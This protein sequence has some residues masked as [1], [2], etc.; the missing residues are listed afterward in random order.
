MHT[1]SNDHITESSTLVQVE[2]S[3]LVGS[4]ALTTAGTAAAVVPVPLAVEDL[5]GS[6]L[7][8]RLVGLGANSLGNTASEAVAS[9]DGGKEGCNRSEDGRGL[10]RERLVVEVNVGLKE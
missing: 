6:D 4:L 2:D 7:N 3:I 10:H 8:D 1:L 5:A 9:H